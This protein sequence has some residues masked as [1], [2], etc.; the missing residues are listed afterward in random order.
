[1]VTS[2]KFIGSLIAVGSEDGRIKI[3]GENWN[4]LHSSRYL[5]VKVTGITFMSGKTGF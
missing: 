2:F 3:F 1:M 5:A 4:T